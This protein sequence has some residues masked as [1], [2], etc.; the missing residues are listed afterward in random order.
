VDRRK[1][2][3]LSVVAAL[4]GNTEVDAVVR[5]QDYASSVSLVRPTS[6]S[7]VAVDCLQGYVWRVQHVSRASISVAALVCP[8]DSALLAT[9]RY[10]RVAST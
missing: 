7:V 2:S 4:W 6:T 1:G 8:V 9:L 10:A 5:C 3:A